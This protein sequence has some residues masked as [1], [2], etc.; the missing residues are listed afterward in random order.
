[1]DIVLVFRFL[2]S[3]F[4]VTPLSSRTQIDKPE[5]DLEKRNGIHILGIDESMNQL[6][7]ETGEIMIRSKLPEEII[8]QPAVVVAGNPAGWELSD[9]GCALEIV[10]AGGRGTTVGVDEGDLFV[11]L[12]DVLDVLTR[13]FVLFWNLEL[14][15]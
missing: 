13:G 3:T 8:H 2:A 14:G 10:I 6:D 5:Q 11:L 15:V 7:A 12:V 9:I 4:Y 1:M